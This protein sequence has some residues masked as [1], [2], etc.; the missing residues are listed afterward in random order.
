MTDPVD[1]DIIKVSGTSNPNSVASIIA[2]AV[3]AGHYPKI[4]AIGAGPV[5]QASK[6]CAI[7]RGFVAP[8][9]IDLYYIIGFDDIKGDSGDTISAVTWKPVVR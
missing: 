5:N 4:R 9:G 8:R 3:V 2:R 6:A 7:A 1:E